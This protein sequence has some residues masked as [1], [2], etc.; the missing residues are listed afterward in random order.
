MT[1]RTCEVCHMSVRSL[2]LIQELRF[3]TIL[4][5]SNATSISDEI[6]RGKVVDHR[7]GLRSAQN[8][9]KQMKPNCSYGLN[10]LFLRSKPVNLEYKGYPSSGT[11]LYISGYRPIQVSDIYRQQSE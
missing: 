8:Y 3:Q 4:R 7:E 9:Q 5:G 6:L 11:N 10:H 1:M 2:H